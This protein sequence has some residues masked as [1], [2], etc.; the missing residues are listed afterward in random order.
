M[1]RS[2]KPGARVRYAHEHESGPTS[3]C[4]STTGSTCSVRGRPVTPRDELSIDFLLPPDLLEL[5]LRAIEEHE[6]QVGG[7]VQAF[8]Q[9]IFRRHEGRV[10]PAGCGEGI[11]T[12]ERPSPVTD[13]DWDPERARA[14]ADRAVDLW[15]ELL[16]RLPDMPVSGRWTAE[17]IH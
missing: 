17:E 9:D 13:L 11:V 16:E 14:F 6:S 8:G 4:R 1:R 15:Q 12:I 10:V 7:I 3:S 5:K 2:A